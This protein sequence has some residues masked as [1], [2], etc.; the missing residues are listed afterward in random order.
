[1]NAAPKEVKTSAVLLVEGRDEQNFFEAFLKHLGI[2]NVTVLQLTGKPT[3]DRVTAAVNI[4]GFK[5]AMAYAIIRDADDNADNAFRSVHNILRDLNQ[6]YPNTRNAFAQGTPKVGVYIIP[7][8]RDAGMLEDLCMSTVEGHPVLP[9]LEAF[10]N[11]IDGKV[12]FPDPPDP[13]APRTSDYCHPNNPHKAKAKAFLAA[14]KHDLP[15]LGVAAQ[16]GVWDFDH[17]CLRE[18]KEFLGQLASVGST[19]PSPSPPTDTV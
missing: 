1:V 8:D 17:V 14:N 9:C 12:N 2:T 11:C 19:A 18:L 7:G 5:Q 16:K 4:P 13:N 10:M 3:K 6:P 15:N